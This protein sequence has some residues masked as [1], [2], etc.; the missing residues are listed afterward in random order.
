VD[1]GGVLELK[2]PWA[3]SGCSV[4]TPY[5]SNCVGLDRPPP[6]GPSRVFL[7]AK[8]VG[9]R[10]HMG[11]EAPELLEVEGKALSFCVTPRM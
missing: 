4:L 2:K 10:A 3:L 8:E 6:G 9:S 5:V 11:P 1:Y 7:L